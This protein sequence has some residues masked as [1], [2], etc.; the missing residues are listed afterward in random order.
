MAGISVEQRIVEIAVSDILLNKIAVTQ[1]MPKLPLHEK[2]RGKN[3][4]MNNPIML[5][6][7]EKSCDISCLF[8]GLF[9]LLVS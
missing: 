6:N 9:I 5:A 2:E 4:I 1:R 7:T 3:S 8:G